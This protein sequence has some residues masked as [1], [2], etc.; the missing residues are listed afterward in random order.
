VQAALL[1]IQPHFVYQQSAEL[2]VPVRSMGC[3]LRSGYAHSTV[4][5]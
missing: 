2:E 1:L 3:Q 4:L 5:L